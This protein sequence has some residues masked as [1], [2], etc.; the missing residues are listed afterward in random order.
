MKFDFI[1]NRILNFL[2]LYNLLNYF[3]V[4]LSSI[5]YKKYETQWDS[6]TDIINIPFDMNGIEIKKHTSKTSKRISK[7]NTKNHNKELKQ[8]YQIDI[9]NYQLKTRKQQKPKKHYQ[10]RE[11]NMINNLIFAEDNYNLNLVDIYIK[12]KNF[13]IMN[14]TLN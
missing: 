7:K 11:K 14:L 5:T 1:L 9:N 4:V 10:R 12:K 2:G 3:P 8:L 6:I 13:R